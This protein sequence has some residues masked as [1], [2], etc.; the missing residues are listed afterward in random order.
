MDE[1]KL[2]KTIVIMIAII[3]LL[4]L[5]VVPLP[6]ALILNAIFLPIII[7]LIIVRRRLTR[8]YED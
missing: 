4:S 1:N 8:Y 5:F 2:D 6:R 3:A 7:L